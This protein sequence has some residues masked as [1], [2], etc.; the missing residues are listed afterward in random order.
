MNKAVFLDRDGTI[1]VDTGYIGNPDLVELYPG[2]SEGIRII[3]ETLNFY[4]IVISNQSGITRGLISENDV[5]S[6][7]DKINNLLA[8]S[9]TK[10]DAFYY[11]PFHPQFDSA[12]E[13]ECRKPSPRMVFDSSK[14]FNIDLKN[15]FFIGDRVSDM[16]CAY[17]AGVSSILITNT[18]SEAEL[19]ELKNSQ[20]SPNFVTDNFMDAVRFIEKSLRGDI[21]AS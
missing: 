6:V 11:C 1:N 15:S 7:N 12:E 21:I 3:R 18:I 9:N 16:E 2:V 10:I 17:N 4:V 20:N 5:K 19:I 14:T 13:C 8:N